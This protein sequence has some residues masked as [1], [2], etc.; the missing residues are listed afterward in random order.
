[1]ED[2]K[3]KRVTYIDQPL[4]KK[5]NSKSIK[6]GLN[7][8]LKKRFVDNLDEKIRLPLTFTM[9]HG[10]DDGEV[11]CQFAYFF[12]EQKRGVE[13]WLD[14]PWEDYKTLPRAMVPAR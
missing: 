10:P 14:M 5:I 3:W 9:P 1:M 8:T 13:L 11:R 4:L 7:K 6:M 2:T 12:S